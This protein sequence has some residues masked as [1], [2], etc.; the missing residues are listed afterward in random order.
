MPLPAFSF[1]C[2]NPFCFTQVIHEIFGAEYS[3]F[4]TVNWDIMKDL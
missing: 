2:F 1:F 4:I 3:N